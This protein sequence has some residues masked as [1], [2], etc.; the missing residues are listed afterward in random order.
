MCRNCTDN[1]GSSE[2]ADRLGGK[3][4]S[5]QQS[6]YLSCVRPCGHRLD[7]RSLRVR[8]ISRRTPGPFQQLFLAFT[9]RSLLVLRSS[10]GQVS[11]P[12]GAR[13]TCEPQQPSTPKLDQPL[14][15]DKLRQLPVDSKVVNVPC[16]IC[17]PKWNPDGRS[18]GKLL[19]RSA[20]L[21]FPSPQVATVND[22]DFG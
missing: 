20:R 12:S 21:I 8:E 10:R 2:S 9:C 19:C 4:N 18:R 17:A 22:I 1:F 16:R 11:P 3:A 13:Q 7:V 14:A 6:V 15:L 5:E